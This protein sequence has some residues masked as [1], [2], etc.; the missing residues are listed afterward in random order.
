MLVLVCG[1]QMAAF[2]TTPA[3]A[4]EYTLVADAKNR[5]EFQSKATLESFTGKAKAMKVDLDVDTTDLRH[6]SGTI[7]VDLR[8]LDTGIDL[9][10]KHM[11]ENHLRCD[12]FPFAVFTLDS[13][14][15]P[16][17]VAALTAVPESVTVHGSMALHGVTRQIS[18]PGTVARAESKKAAA[19]SL[20][21]V[22]EFPIRLPDYAIPRPEFLFLKL[23]EEIKIVVDLTVAPTP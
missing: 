19:G 11:C 16:A 3:L 15:V 5:V 12:S 20:K 21:L 4:A 9:R 10:N 18:L 23:S 8:T 6:A 1:C 22:T 2:V 7:Q 14:S 13:V 17:G